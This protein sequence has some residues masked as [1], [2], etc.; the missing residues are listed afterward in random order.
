MTFGRPSMIPEKYL[1]LD[2]PLSNLQMVGQPL[3]PMLAPQ[4]DAM[5]FAATM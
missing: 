3:M 2:M 4:M 5:F 1:K